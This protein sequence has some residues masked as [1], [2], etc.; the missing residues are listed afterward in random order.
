MNWG[1]MLPNQSIFV[2]MHIFGTFNIRLVRSARYFSWYAFCPGECVRLC[3]QTDSTDCLK[4]MTMGW[5]SQ[6][7]I[8]A[9]NGEDFIMRKLSSVS[10]SRT[11]H[12]TCKAKCW[13]T[14]IYVHAFFFVVFFCHILGQIKPNIIILSNRKQ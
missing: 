13:I 12:V 11:Y 9:Y 4:F 6:F 1:I 8:I 2:H 10:L 7:V 5:S 3:W 14:Y